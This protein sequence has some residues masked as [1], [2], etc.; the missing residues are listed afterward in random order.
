MGINIMKNLDY[1]LNFVSSY[2]IIRHPFVTETLTVERVI[3]I[4]Y[5]V[6]KPA[7]NHTLQKGIYTFFVF[8]STVRNN[9]YEILKSGNRILKPIH[10]LFT[11]NNITSHLSKHNGGNL[12]DTS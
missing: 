1:S 9:H 5:H 7:V 2:Y 6:I 4:Q 10:D 12:T 3:H 11:R 8:D